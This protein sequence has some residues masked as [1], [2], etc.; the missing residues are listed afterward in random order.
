MGAVA[1]TSEKQPPVSSGEPMPE[2]VERIDLARQQ[3]IQCLKDRYGTEIRMLQDAHKKEKRALKQEN[4]ELKNDIQVQKLIN[5]VL[6]RNN[7][8][9]NDGRSGPSNRIAASEVSHEG[10]TGR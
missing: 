9:N 1:I 3:E 2:R 7:E 6:R 10:S 4:Q 5:T 8:C